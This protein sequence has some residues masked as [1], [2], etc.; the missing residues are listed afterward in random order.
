[1]AYKDLREWLKLVEEL[2]EL[3]VI[4][5]ADWDEELGILR[6]LATTKDCDVPTVLFDKI[7]DYGPGYRVLCGMTGSHNRLA[8]TMGI[9]LEHAKTNRELITA[10]RE[11]LKNMKLTPP[12][13]VKE[14][15]VLEFVHTGED[16]DLFEFPAPRWHMGDGGRYIGTWHCMISRDPVEGWINM[17]TY[18]TMIYDK[19]TLVTMTEPGRHVVQHRE[20]YWAKGK[21]MPVVYCFGAD[22]LLAQV[23]GM[24]IPYGVSEMDYVGAIKGDP[25]G[26]FEGKM[27]GLPIPAHAEI[28]VE[29]E[30]S[31]TET[32][33]EGPYAEWT[34]YTTYERHMEP[35][36]KVL[37]VMHR[38]NPI[39]TGLTTSAS[40]KASQF[41]KEAAGVDHRCI[42]RSAMIW[43]EM[44]AAGV[45]GITGV[46]CHPAGGSRFWIVVSIKQMAPGHAKQAATVATQCGSAA[47]SGRYTVVVDD[48]ID[49]TNDFAVLWAICTRSNPEKDIDILRGCRTGNLDPMFAGEETLNSRAIINACRPYRESRDFVPVA[50]FDPAIRQRVIK[51][52]GDSLYE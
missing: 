6:Y 38:K 47:F 16:I 36:V 46:Y 39:I 32:L 26:V 20:K 51:R 3:K 34:G 49:P 9:D 37:S 31:L 35:A 14:G 28:A 4:E 29:A 15:P 50:K 17:G 19:N 30:V 41:G 45:P 23:A 18:R 52:Y 2:G 11:K 5:G 42:L 27:T 7:K 1:M 48:D 24:E 43:N 33:Q 22:P 13:V 44:E 21:P 10:V 25:M 8:L 12:K 40:P